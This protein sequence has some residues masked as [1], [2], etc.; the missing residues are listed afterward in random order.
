MHA[1]PQEAH[2][3]LSA[4]LQL[5]KAPQEVAGVGSAG[6]HNLRQ[7]PPGQLR[8][9]MDEAGLPAACGANKDGPPAPLD[10][11][12]HGLQQ[13]LLGGQQLQL[14]PLWQGGSCP[15]CT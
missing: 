7:G 6:E 13:A 8:C 4:G 9:E 3:Q 14:L 10:A 12:E 5:L 11:V 1:T 15:A 2:L